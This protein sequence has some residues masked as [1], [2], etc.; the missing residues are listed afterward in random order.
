MTL[1]DELTIINEFQKGFQAF[2][3]ILYLKEKN[4]KEFIK[5]S[6]YF[7]KWGSCRVDILNS[8]NEENTINILDFTNNLKYS[9]PS[10][11]KTK[12][13]QGCIVQSDEKRIKFKIECCKTGKLEIILRSSDYR[14]KSRKRLPIYLIYTKMI[15]DDEEIQIDNQ[16][17]SHDTPFRFFK[18]CQDNQV[19]DIEIE[20]KTI[21]DVLPNLTQY[22]NQI[23][24]DDYDFTSLNILY[25]YLNESLQNFQLT[26]I[27][28]SNL[29]LF[30]SLNN[31]INLLYYENKNLKKDL[32]DSIKNQEK[33]L[34]SYNQQF[35]TI[36]LDYEMKPRGILKKTQELCVHLLD[37]IVNIC[38]KYQLDYWLDYGTLLGSI[39]HEGFILWDDDVDIGM[40]RKD[41]NK[42]LQIIDKELV[43][44]NLDDVITINIDKTF[45]KALL[46]FIQIK[47]SPDS[48]YLFAGLDIFPYDYLDNNDPNLE[49]KYNEEQNYFRKNMK[50]SFNRKDLMN[51]VYNNLNLDLNQQQYLIPGVD[52]VM[53]K[54]QR[55][56]FN[57]YKTNEIFPLKPV[58]FCNNTYYG[59]NNPD[60]YLKKIY[61]NYHQ[62]PRII[63]KHRRVDDLK[64][65]P[66]NYQIFENEIRKM[67]K[68]NMQ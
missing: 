46:T 61:G 10:W 36:F 51:H 2:Y 19:L 30:N 65:N 4:S 56:S 53:G 41:F 59:P 18:N 68:I 9:Y 35:S 16:L 55:Y 1:N 39:R 14:Y 38:E 48:K 45:N 3:E 20:F 52:N 21:F 50:N 17:I 57:I 40:T 11:M 5:H 28:Q 12:N 32:Q 33:I 24:A 15:V 25:D 7:E 60:Y 67:K 42:F 44:N 23:E 8:G 43:E 34:D 29:C 66:N 64:K 49:K 22:L 63:E 31:K 62:M 26:N 54:Y 6:N 37:F 47:Y 58:K 13:G 27:K